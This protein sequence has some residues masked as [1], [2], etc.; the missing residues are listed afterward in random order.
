MA[1]LLLVE[2]DAG[3]AQPLMRALERAGHSTQW[4]TT[5]GDAEVAAF[6]SLPDRSPASITA[7]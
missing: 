7:R 1:S 2:D 5:G 4:V 3:I 6:D